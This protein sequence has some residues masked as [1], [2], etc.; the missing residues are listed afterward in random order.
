M[1]V[2]GYDNRD[3]TRIFRPQ[4]TTVNMP[5]YEMGHKAAELLVRQIAGGDSVEEVKI[6][7]RLVVRETCGAGPSLRT[8][9]DVL[10]ATSVRRLLLN[11]QPDA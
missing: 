8:G 5:V 9:E 11:K 3:F 10:N 1:A 6:K 4:M 7:G 2:V